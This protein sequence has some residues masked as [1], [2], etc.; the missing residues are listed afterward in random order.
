MNCLDDSWQVLTHFPPGSSA[1]IR[2]CTS[3]IY[4]ST[5]CS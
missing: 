2:A 3:I 5:C 1:C 4:E